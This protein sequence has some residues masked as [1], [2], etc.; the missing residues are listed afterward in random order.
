MSD[1]L[2]RSV[3]LA[4]RR[5][6]GSD[7]SWNAAT[8]FQAAVDIVLCNHP[9]LDAR[10]ACEEAAR[11][12]MMPPLGTGRR[13]RCVRTRTAAILPFPGLAARERVA[14]SR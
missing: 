2:H 4:Y 11:M 3:W 7:T 1:D 10:S 13:P 8:S 9:G 6:V 12:V 14:S 5:A